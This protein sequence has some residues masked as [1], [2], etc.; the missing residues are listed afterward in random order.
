MSSNIPDYPDANLLKIKVSHPGDRI[1]DELKESLR[2]SKAAYRYADN[3]QEIQITLELNANRGFEGNSQ[4]NITIN[5]DDRIG[6]LAEVTRPI[7]ARNINIVNA[8]CFAS[9]HRSFLMN[10]TLMGNQT[11]WQ[12]L[13]QEIENIEGMPDVNIRFN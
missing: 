9:D 11:D 8:N 12:S 4:V 3:R 2:E 5:G 7:S 13:R 1:Y 10:F 6:L